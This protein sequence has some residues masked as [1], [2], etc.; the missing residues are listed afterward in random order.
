MKGNKVKV[1]CQKIVYP[2]IRYSS[3]IVK[4]YELYLTNLA[5]FNFDEFLSLL[6][7]LDL[8]EETDSAVFG[9]AEVEFLA[10]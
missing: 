6:A 4:Y 5:L 9:V 10:E 2:L 1:F 3:K 8:R 7:T